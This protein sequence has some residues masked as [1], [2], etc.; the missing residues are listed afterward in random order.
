MDTTPFSPFSAQHGFAVLAG[1]VAGAAIILAGR[2]GGQPRRLA[3]AVLAFAN[4][5]AW[6]LGQLAWAGYPKD[7]DNILP[8]HLCD[9]AAI[10]AGF[11]LLTGNHLLRKLTYFWGLAATLQALLT[12][13]IGMGFP[14]LPFLMFFVH[15]FAVVIAAVWFPVVEQ[16]RPRR[17]WW[18]DPLAAY[19]WS[20][21]YLIF[22][23]TANT[24]LGTNFAF[25]ASLPPN[26]SL[27]DHLG[28]W[29]WYLLAMQP[30]AIALFLILALPF[31]FGGKRS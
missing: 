26:P 29:P 9:V 13:A 27:L 21:L 22:A 16:W 15:H 11:A 3:H 12:P 20:V 25:A 4:L 7:L 23:M 1:V 28:P 14:H 8:F 6:P 24:M 5:S 30:I 2:R 17:P 31:A 18:R 10:T 19:G